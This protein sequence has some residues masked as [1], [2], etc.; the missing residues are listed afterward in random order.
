MFLAAAVQM[1]ST[2][3]V[4]GNFA[5]VEALVARAA[6]AGASFVATPEATD[7]LGPHDRKVAL[8]EPVGGP[9]SQRYAELAARHGMWLLIG[10]VAERGDDRRCYNTSLLFGPDGALVATYRKLHLFDV[11][12]PG[13]VRFQES[14]T[15]LPGDAVVTAATPLGTLGLSI[16]YDLRFPELY[17][18]LRDGGADILCVP[19]AFTARTGKAHWLPLLQARAIET[20]CFVVAPGQV[21]EH[22]DGGLRA[23]HGHTVIVD[24]WGEV[25][26]MVGDGPGLALAEIDLGRLARIRAGIPV[27]HN[28]RLPLD[29]G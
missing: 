1:T 25:A 28:R 3:D 15:T 13:G 20:Q 17:R 14:A 19:S 7:Y 23:S 26:A 6:A 16:C 24:P 22:D 5:Q 4:A 10:S 9:S 18:A 29:E 21:G 8:A 12:V 27:A 2:S 11:D